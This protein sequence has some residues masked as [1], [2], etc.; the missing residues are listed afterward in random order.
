MMT[1][2]VGEV[3]HFAAGGH[4][5]TER[6]LKRMSTAFGLP[7]GLHFL[8]SAESPQCLEEAC[9]TYVS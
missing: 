4:P 7:L 6:D 3:D 5:G 2:E 1:E 9:T 8:S